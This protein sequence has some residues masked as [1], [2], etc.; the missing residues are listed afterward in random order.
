[1]LGYAR[2]GKARLGY[3]GQPKAWIGKSKLGKARLG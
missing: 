3:T 1:M 2:L